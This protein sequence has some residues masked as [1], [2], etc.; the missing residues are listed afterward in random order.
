MLASQVATTFIV[1][2]VAG[3]VARSVVVE[4]QQVGLGGNLLAE[5]PKCSVRRHRFDPE[6]G[7]DDDGAGGT[8]VAREVDP[9]EERPPRRPEEDRLGRAHAAT[10]I[11]VSRIPLSARTVPY[12]VASSSPTS[13]TA[14]SL[15]GARCIHES[16]GSNPGTS[17][18]THWANRSDET[19][20]RHPCRSA[21]GTG[22]EAEVDV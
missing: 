9:P 3:R 4:A 7:T 6:R 13:A 22:R 20:R 12:G 17:T 18:A 11:S 2:F 1:G 10:T 14:R 8:V 15:P 16:P 19:T 21:L 5:H